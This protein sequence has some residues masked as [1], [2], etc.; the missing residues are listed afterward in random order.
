MNDSCKSLVDIALWRAK[1]QP[2]KIVY[3]FLEDGE[4]DERTMTFLELDQ[5]SK[6]IGSLLQQHTSPGERVLILVPAGLDFI[7]S[8]FGSLYAGVI[9]I[10]VPP[11]HYA[12]IDKT[13]GA[14]LRIL[15]DA[16]PT[17]VILD[18]KL[19]AAIK[20]SPEIA[21]KFERIHFIHVNDSLMDRSADWRHPDLTEDDLALLQYTSGSTYTPKGVMITHKNLLNNLGA[22]EKAMGLTEKD[23][24]VFWLPPFHDMGLIGG[25]LQPLYSGITA[26]LI[27]HLLFLQKP[28]RWLSAISKYKATTSGAPNFAYE[29]CLKKVKPEQRDQLDLS[30]WEIAINGAEPINVKTM[31]DFKEY[32]SSCGF[33][34]TAFIPCYGL[35]EATL[36]ATAASKDRP[37]I[38]TGISKKGLKLNEVKITSDVEKD[39]H[40]IV[41]CG[42]CI[43]EHEIKIV[44]P[45]SC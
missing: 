9:A 11:P 4:S 6:T 31:N 39:Y 12:R 2:E 28:L 10:P 34:E 40:S 44:N 41:S 37:F 43:D 17:V 42:R 5:H 25:I 19:H 35:A 30:S 13:L 27:P 16:K 21:R 33:W 18:Q 3:R 26:T 15:N 14:T 20:K 8:F 32:F 22:I 7:T 24:T 36:M 45:K 29:L 23:E 38:T 1:N